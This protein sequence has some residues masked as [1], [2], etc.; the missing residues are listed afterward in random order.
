MFAV[1]FLKLKS[2]NAAKKC[3]K[4][5]VPDHKFTFEISPQ[6]PVKPKRRRKHDAGHVSAS[7]LAEMWMKINNLKAIICL[8]RNE[9]AGEERR[10]KRSLSV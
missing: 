8:R 10:T 1:F 5:I 6:R 2:T 4:Q 7:V 9:K 3:L